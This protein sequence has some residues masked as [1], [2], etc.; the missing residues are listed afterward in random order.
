[1]TSTRHRPQSPHQGMP[2]FSFRLHW[3]AILWGATLRLHFTR[4]FAGGLIFG[5]AGSVANHHPDLI[6]AGIVTSPFVALYALALAIVGKITSIFLDD[7]A[8]VIVGLLSFFLLPFMIC[9]DPLLWLLRRQFPRLV[10]VE[11]F[12]FIN[13]KA[14]I[15]ALDPTKLQPEVA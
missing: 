15:F 5:I 10:P 12:S 7:L 6:G 8:K 3:R 2:D 4:Y 13:F 11:K 9:G 1:M 14:V